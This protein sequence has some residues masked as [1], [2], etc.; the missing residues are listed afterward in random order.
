MEP[1]YEQT[2]GQH[3]GRV[4]ALSVRLLRITRG[5]CRQM[6]CLQLL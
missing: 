4:T 6:G 5:D 2:V 1:V 3:I